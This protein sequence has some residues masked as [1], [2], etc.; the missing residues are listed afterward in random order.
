MPTPKAYILN[1][2]ANQNTNYSSWMSDCPVECKLVETAI[3]TWEPPDDT[4]IV[5]THMHYRWDEISA[6]RRI[7][8]STQI[9][10]LILAD[11]IL[12]YRNTWQNPTIA[13]GS[14]FQPMLGHK[15]ACIGNSQAR[16]IESWGNSGKCEVTG[17]PRFDSVFD[18]EYLPIQKDGPFRLLIAT[19]NSPAFD[20]AQRNHVVQS[21]QA[22]QQRFEKNQQI[23]ER[24]VEVTWRLTDG[25]HEELNLPRRRDQSDR[26]HTLSDMVELSDAVI[27][28]PSTLYLDSV[29]KN[30]PT[31]ILDFNNTPAYVNSA[32]TISAPLHINDVL[33]ELENPPPPKLF[34]QQ[35]ALRDHLEHRGSAKQRMHQL[36]ETMVEIGVKA[37]AS[38]ES[39]HFP[40]KI[41]QTNPREIQTTE[42]NWDTHC[43]YPNNPVFQNTQVTRL[44]Q[45]LNQ[46]I[47][48]LNQLPNELQK[49][50]EQ[51]QKKRE[52]IEKQKQEIQQIIESK[53][54]NIEIKDTFIDNLVEQMDE[55][56]MRKA[57]I[58]QRKNAHIESLSAMFSEA[59]AE[60]KSSRVNYADQAVRL[61]DLKQQIEQFAAAICNE[62]LQTRAA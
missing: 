8:E 3:H 55:L 59:N 29:T 19:A 25:L 46:A 38:N 9:P 35:T 28:T 22:L 2:Y 37:R 56:L 4:G 60:L 58:I 23:N 49:K 27:T 16:H 53:K 31:A 47:A 24:D 57:E 30:R 43:L 13:D 40:Q 1:P 17:L 41:L 6:L 62:D 61:N 48:R 11:G 54:K 26:P 32:W 7:Y 20:A 50:R 44:Q 21:I 52:H 33:K 5:I 36:I 12:E 39:L 45:E 10:I 51:L 18:S 14:I 15:L 34:Y 42:T